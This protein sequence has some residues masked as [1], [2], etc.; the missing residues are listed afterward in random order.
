VN[1]WQQQRLL[2]RLA[3]FLIVSVVESMLTQR[4]HCIAQTVITAP[5][6]LEEGKCGD[7]CDYCGHIIL[8]SDEL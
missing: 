3:V 8:F 4:K 6:S 7:K 1:T 5:I 2:R